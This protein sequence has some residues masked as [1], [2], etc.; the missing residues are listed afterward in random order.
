MPNL[1]LKQMQ[2]QPD[3]KYKLL[4][5]GGG[6]G[7]HVFPA[8]AIADAVVQSGIGVDIL[9]VGA[10][11]KLEMEKV[12]RA[13]YPIEGL[14]VMGFPRK[15][16]LKIFRFFVRLLQSMI[17]AR[18]IVKEFAP[19]CVVGVGGYASGP[20]LRRAS[21]MGIP[22]LI[23]EQNSYAGITNKMLAAKAHKI[24]VAFEGM[25]KY[26]PAEKIVFT[27]NPVRKDILRMRNG[28]EDACAFFR[29]DPSLKVILVLGGS[30]GAATINRSILAGLHRIGESVQVLWQCGKLYHEE[31]KIALQ[32]AGHQNVILMP[33]IERMDLAYG[34]ADVI[35]S[36]A[37]AITISELACI[38]KPV[39]LVPS[40]NVA[41]DHQTKNAQALVSKDAALVI[42]DM[43]AIQKL[44]PAALDLLNNENR[45]TQL[46]THLKALGVQDA[47]DKIA[48]EVIEL[49]MKKK[50]GTTRS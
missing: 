41:E 21:R 12:P 1:N 44:V 18:S 50:R 24:C 29:L 7:G 47:A 19:D 3:N 35:V 14:P 8:I 10:E 37:G 5:S 13:G 38:G 4:I 45:M 30:L 25:E 32:D 42:R 11:G 17:K 2:N 36:R 23:Q 33:F 46:A 43:D 31:I 39:I 48:F 28:K 20:V 26:F 34:V 9:F 27:G 40:P 49:M 22:T 16:S 15:P 6:T